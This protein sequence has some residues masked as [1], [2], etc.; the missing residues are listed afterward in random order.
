MELIQAQFLLE[1]TKQW[2]KI[3]LLETLGG[4]MGARFTKDGKDGVQVHLT[5]TQFACG[6]N[7][8]GIST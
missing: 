4:G 8:N 2:K 7:R 6:S 3:C 1:L 5:N